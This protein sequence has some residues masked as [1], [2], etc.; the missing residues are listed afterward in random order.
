LAE[1]QTGI[2][3]NRPLRRAEAFIIESTPLEAANAPL[4]MRRRSK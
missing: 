2:H 1:R 3:L 4:A